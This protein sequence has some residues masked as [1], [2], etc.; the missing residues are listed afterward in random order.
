MAATA[1][2]MP[3]GGDSDT[4]H[5]EFTSKIFQ[6]SGAKF[7][8]CGN[9]QEPRFFVTVGGLKASMTCNTLME[10]FHIP[11]DSSD[12]RLM[13]TAVRG[14]KYVPEIRPGDAIP[15]ELL[16]GQ[17]SWSVAPKH[18]QIAQNRLQVQLLSW[19]SGKEILLTNRD[20]IEM[21]LGQIENKAKLKEAFEAAAVALGRDKKDYEVV[22]TEIEQLAHELA[23]IEALRDRFAKID[24]LRAKFQ[25]LMGEYTSD[26]R[27]KQEI[28]RI[29][30]LHQ[31]AVGFY[32]RHFTEIDAQTS[33]I[34]GALKSRDRQVTFIRKVRDDLHFILREWDGLL[35]RWDEIPIK[36][37]LHMD[38][39][40]SDTYRLL[41][42]KFASAKSMLNTAQK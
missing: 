31:K 33:E 9:A 20:E 23:Y 18:R 5:F 8:L 38:R 15:S 29:T 24:A 7:A 25:K 3:L 35:K 10:E 6:M 4:T 12:A 1:L 17:A 16:N 41:A 27:L 11:R 37:A 34:V 32:D 42:A 30:I 40:L 19:V 13:T 36:K 22:L 21:F 26:S 2:K 28:Q 39:L 14:L